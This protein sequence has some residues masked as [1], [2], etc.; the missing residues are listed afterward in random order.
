MR[1]HDD[2]RPSLAE[3][4]Q[5]GQGRSDTSVVRDGRDT[6]GLGQRNVQVGAHQD[7]SAPDIEVGE[8]L[9]E[10]SG[11]PTKRTRSTKRFE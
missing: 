5:R 9:H 4:T 2:P 6:V 8:G 1:D 11:A 7:P 3:G 10:F